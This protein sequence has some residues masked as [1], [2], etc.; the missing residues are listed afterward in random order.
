MDPVVLS[1]GAFTL[2][3]L[4]R[5]HE[6]AE[7][8]EFQM[9]GLCFGVVLFRIGLSAGLLLRSPRRESPQVKE[10]EDQTEPPSSDG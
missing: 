1:A 9:A 2:H 6:N 7:A 3:F 4:I 5:W 10:R 8:R